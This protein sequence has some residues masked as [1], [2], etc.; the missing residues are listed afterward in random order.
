MAQ[1]KP[2]LNLD[3]DLAGIAGYDPQSMPTCNSSNQPS[4]DCLMC[5]NPI[6]QNHGAQHE[7]G[8]CL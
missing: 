2:L 1:A 5:K 6:F 3:N 8:R 4:D 7:N